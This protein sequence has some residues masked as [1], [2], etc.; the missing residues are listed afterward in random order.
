MMLGAP[1][2]RLGALRALRQAKRIGPWMT[3]PRDFSSLTFVTE[4]GAKGDP[5]LNLHCLAD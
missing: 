4:V 5:A 1:D 3:T 2:A